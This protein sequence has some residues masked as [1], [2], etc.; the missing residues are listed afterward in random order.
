MLG[1]H[2]LSKGL[3]GKPKM[4]AEKPPVTM[5]DENDPGV[6]A[7]GRNRARRMRG[8]S[9]RMSTMMSDEYSDEKLG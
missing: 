5:P 9:G 8:R 7:A 1:N 2:E 4:P 3:F 6:M